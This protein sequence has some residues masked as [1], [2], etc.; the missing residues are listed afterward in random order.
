MKQL[1]KIGIVASLTLGSLLGTSAVGNTQLTNAH[2]ASAQQTPYYTYSGLFNYS[3]NATL[4]N[5]Y[6]YKALQHDNFKY[7][8]LKVGTSTYDEVKKALGNGLKK[9]YVS[10]GVT[11]YEK[12]DVIV[13]INSKNQ[14][15]NLT[16]LIDKVN[17]SAQSIRKH[18][19]EGE[20]Y[21]AKTT[22]VAFYP[23]NSIVIKAKESK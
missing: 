1:T 21:D 3:G 8:G 6:F 7:E 5:A 14:L 16:L 19:K 10:K 22:Q 4:D 20:I 9:Y 13:G 12:N 15:V 23:G 17:H 11:Y 2:A 18:V